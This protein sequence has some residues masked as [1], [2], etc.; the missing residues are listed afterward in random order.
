MVR[1][2]RWV[3]V[4][5]GIAALAA[6]A[7]PPPPPPPPVPVAPPKLVVTPPRPSAPYGASD[8]VVIPSVGADGLRHTLLVDAVDAQLVWNL[9]AAYNVAA[10][11]CTAPRF[12]DIADNYRAFLKTH[13]KTLNNANRGVDGVFQA[14]YGKDFVRK[15]ETYMTQVYNY[16]AYPPTLPNFCESA[17]VMSRESAQIQTKDL[18]AF[19]YRSFA[20]FTRVYEDFYRAYEKYRAD[21]AD[22]EAKYGAG[23]N[24]SRSIG[25][26]AG[27]ARPGV[28]TN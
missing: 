17:L 25:A 28:G 18:P 8:N 21:L 20:Q 22:W 10:L 2:L 9:R 24:S 11:N 13:A 5:A 19:S 26:E 7:A 23:Q 16:F 4:S 6:C 3:F 14:R 1:V 27:A 12:V 15:R